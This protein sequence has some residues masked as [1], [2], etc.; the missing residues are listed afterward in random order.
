MKTITNNNKITLEMSNSE[1]LVLIDWLSRF[2]ENDN[3]NFFEDQ[4]E[5]RILW[6]MEAELEKIES[7]IFNDKYLEMLSKARDMVRD[8][9]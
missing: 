6:D 1:A 9:E 7:L 4:A 5:R 3:D 2:N 8:N